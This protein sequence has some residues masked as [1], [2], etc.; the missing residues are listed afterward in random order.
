MEDWITMRE[1][2]RQGV[3]IGE[4]ARRSGRDPK[5]VRKVLR[6]AAPQPRPNTW[7]P[8]TGKL[9]PYEAYL[10]QRVAQGCLN[11][12]V[13]LEEITAQGYTGKHTVL[14]GFLAPLRQEQRRQREATERFETGPG[15]QAQVDW[16]AFG[17]IW[18][19]EVEAWQKLSAFV[20]TLGYSRAQFLT[21]VT[22]CDEEH[23]LACHLGAFEA[24]G[25]PEQILYD[26][27]KTAVVGRQAD[28]APDLPEPLLGLC[29]L[30]RLYAEALSALPAP[31]QRESRTGHSLRAPKL[32]GA[33]CPRGGQRRA[34]AGGTE[35][36][37]GGMDQERGEPAPAWHD[38][39]R[40]PGPPGRGTAAA[41]SG[42]GPSSL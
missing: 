20:F 3:A 14:R 5:T 16:G 23:F 10:Q 42:D 29:P 15:K 39:R 6:A 17:R 7:H 11:G 8:G 35:R 25:I 12:A 31:D 30:L 21:F 28:G 9:A 33:G 22:R 37:G 27:L 13:L 36:A 2:A 24:L 38:G 19:P 18:S 1:W 34:G 41:G 26:N 32:L 40:R 4:I